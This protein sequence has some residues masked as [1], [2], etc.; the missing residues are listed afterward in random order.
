MELYVS[1]LD[2]M[3]PKQKLYTVDLKWDIIVVTDK[4]WNK[5]YG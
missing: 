5:S 1:L 4:P 2:L 3:R